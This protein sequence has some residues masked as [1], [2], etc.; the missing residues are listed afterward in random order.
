[1]PALTGCSPA[2]V[3][4]GAGTTAG[5]AIAEERT[6]GEQASDASIKLRLNA[7]WL[8]RMPERY[9]ELGATVVERRVLVTGTVPRPEDRV[10]AI[11]LAWTVDGVRSV[12]NR[13]EVAESDGLGGFLRDVT[14]TAQVESRLTFDT[15]VYSV[16]YTVDTVRGTVYLMGIAQDEGE[17]R[18]VVGHARQVPYV[19]R[20]VDLTRLK[21][22]P[23]PSP[24]PAPEGPGT[25][26]A[27]ERG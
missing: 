14:I 1:V 9:L 20:I 5:L 12:V 4:L 6:V 3:V 27:A 8:E 21:S 19:R 13:I 7:V 11:R 25:V 2:Q 22:D 24:A 17:R 10:E 18:R 23:P 16:N 15:A 26:A